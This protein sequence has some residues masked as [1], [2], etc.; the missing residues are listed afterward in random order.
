ML[1][2]GAS[3][4]V[5]SFLNMQRAS[6]G[7]DPRPL[8]SLRVFLP[9]ERYE[10]AG[11]KAR[12]IEDI[13]ARIERL[14]GVEA[15]A[16][17]NLIPLDGGGMDSAL[18]IDGQEV[19][20]RRAPSVFFAGVTQRYFETLNVPLVRGRN[21]TAAEAREASP[22]ALVNVSFARRFFDTSATRA[23][24]GAS[25]A[26]GLRGAA[27]LGAI[28]PVG[29]RVR[30]LNVDGAPWLT[31]IGVVPDVMTD[32]IGSTPEVPA[33]FAAYPHR[34][35]PTPASSSAPRAGRRG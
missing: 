23:G 1:L 30:L 29:R 10:P 14:P 31:I 20:E 19:D 27:D 34:R 5:R 17:S 28:D 4:F 24:A 6:A 25:G 11:A 18:V 12:R 13:V 16:A 8:M 35:R 7:F 9:G 26:P 33:V 15:A 3:L 21:F 2:V 32:E 22:V